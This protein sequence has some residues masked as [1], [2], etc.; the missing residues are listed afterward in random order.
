MT[1]KENGKWSKTPWFNI[2]YIVKLNYS[3]HIEIISKRNSKTIGS[4]EQISTNFAK[5]ISSHY[6]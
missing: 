4:F 5:V 1:L 2:R 3:E 6:I